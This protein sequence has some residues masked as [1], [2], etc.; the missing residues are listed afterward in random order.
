MINLV[1]QSKPQGLQHHEEFTSFSHTG[2]NDG[3]MVS[4]NPPVM[5]KVHNNVSLNLADSF[6]GQIFMGYS[7]N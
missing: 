5:H 1:K 4:K 6:I 3:F 2:F 7:K